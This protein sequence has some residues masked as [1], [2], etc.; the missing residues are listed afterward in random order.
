[1][2]SADVLIHDLTR[3]KKMRT[4]S[5]LYEL[6]AYSNVS[7]GATNHDGSRRSFNSY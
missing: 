6:W 5:R 4:V 7:L 3:V 1:M 2:K